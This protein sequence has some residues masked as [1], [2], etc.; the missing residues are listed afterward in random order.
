MKKQITTS[1][2]ANEL[3]AQLERVRDPQ[4]EPITKIDMNT[5]TAT[6]A[7]LYLWQD[8]R[9]FNAL[10]GQW[11]TDELSPGNL[12][13]L[14]AG[15]YPGFSEFK[16]LLRP[17]SSLTEEEAKE[18]FRTEYPAG[19]ELSRVQVAPDRVHYRY[20]LLVGTIE[21]KTAIYFDLLKPKQFTYLLSKGFDLFGY[22]ESGK[23]LD[24]TKQVSCIIEEPKD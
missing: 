21:S 18:L 10:N 16:L 14:W 13:K 20:T 3:L 23:A 11:R 15:D 12:D 5:L 9:I 1:Q 17:L 4:I 2:R 8:C 24:K 7:A 19:F 22:I 6:E